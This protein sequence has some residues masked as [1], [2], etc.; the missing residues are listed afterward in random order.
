MPDNTSSRLFN[1]VKQVLNDHPD[2][3]HENEIRRLIQE[4]S[5]L[6]QRPTEI[7]QFLRSFPD[8]FVQLAGGIWRLKS[9]LQAE[10]ISLGLQEIPRSRGDVEIPY[11]INLPSLDS[12]IVFDL[13][14]SG[15]K[16]DRD[17]II[18][19]SAVRIV[20]GQPTTLTT[21]DH[22]QSPAIFNSYVNLQGR[23]L[24]FSLKVKLGFDKHSDWET[25]LQ[26]AP[27]VEEV[28]QNFR[29]WAGDLPLLA[30]NAR[31]DY[32]FLSK[33]ATQINWQITNPIIDTME[34]ACL[35]RP[36]LNTFTLSELSKSFGVCEGQSG[37]DQVEQWANQ[38]E[39][40][41]FSWQGFHNAIVDV[42]VLAAT[43][44]RLIAALQQRL[45]N[46]PDLAREFHRLMP[47]AA[48]ALSIPPIP[49]TPNLDAALKNLPKVVF[50]PDDKLPSLT[51]NFTP[52]NVETQFTQ[53]LDSKGY[54]RRLS[55]L[56]MIKAIGRGL[57]ENRFMAIEAPTGTGKTF[58]YLV[59]SVFWSRT[60]G[61]TVAI[62]T[63]TRLLQDQMANDLLKVHDQLGVDFR[64]TVLKGLSNYLCLDR[65][66]AVYAQ[67]E[68]TSLDQEQRFAWL[69]LLSW[70]TAT[71]TG[72]LDELSYW[73]ITTFPILAQLCDSLR[74]DR[75]ECSYDRCAA[76]SLCFH[77]RAYRQA[78]TSD[79]VVMNHALLLAKDWP[80]SNILFSQVMIDE[81][82]NLED[83][84]TAAATEEVSWDSL[85]YLV[86]RL[87]D[88]RTGQGLLVR[89]KDKNIA[90]D[91]QR[92]VAAAIQ[93]R[94]V[95]I[96]LIRDFGSQL[97][98]YIELNQTKVDPRYGAK[99][100]L[101][102]D[103]RKANPISWQPVQA[104]R[105]RLI[106]ELQELALILQR[107]Q[108]WLIPNRLSIFHQQTQNELTYLY[109]KLR[110]QAE[111]L[112]TL[113]KVGFDSLKVVHWLEVEQATPYE[114]SRITQEYTG[115]YKWAVKRAPVR[116]GPYL[117]ENL[118]KNKQALLLTSATLGTTQE[119]GLGFVLDRLGLLDRIQAPNA[120]KLAPELDYSRSLFAVA[121]YMR[122]DARP[123]E[124]K[125]F[126]DEV[127][128]E[129]GWFF[130]FTGGNGLTLF[131]ARERML[132]AF[133]EVEPTLGQYSISVG[134]QGETA[135]RKALLEEL[136]N[137]PGSV[138]LGLKSF[139]E[140][141]DVPGPN[142][143]YVVMEKL[144]FPMLGEPIIRA[145]A[146]ELRAKEISDFRHYLLPL[147]L[148]LFKQGFGRLIRDE[149]DMGAVLLLD[150]RV[151]SREYW[152]DI[153][154][155]LPG[156][157]DTGDNSK[158][159]QIL[160]FTLDNEQQLSRK[161]V[162]RS[163]A[164]FMSKAPPEWQIDPTWLQSI[165]DLI[166]D[167][168]L[169]G[170]ERLLAQLQ[171]PNI[172]PADQLAAVW[173]KVMLALKELFSFL[174]W[175]LPE[176]EDVVKSILTG[177]DTLVILPTGSGKS[178][179]FQLPALLRDGT[180]L[181]FSPLKSLM[182]DQVDKLIDRGLTVADR[183]DSTQTA[184]E[185][186]RVYQRMRDGTTRLVYIAPERVR[187]PKLIAALRA[188]KNIVQ[189]V[190]DEAHCVYMW[191]QSF[192]PDF[193]YINNLVDQ[194]TQTR[195]Q[196][197]P[198]AAL[199][200]T[201]TPHVRQAIKDQLHLINCQ[202]IATNPNR[203]ELRFVVYN[204]TSPGYRLVSRRDK[205][206][207]LLRILKTADRNDESAI[208]YVS[209]TREA[210]RLTARLEAAG[211]DARY[212]HGKMDDQARQD[213][214]DL[215]LEGQ[216]KIIVATKA[217][218]MGIDKSDVRYVIHFQIPGDLESYFQEAG[219]AGRDH[220]VSWCV[221]LF[222]PDDLYIHE[223]YFIPNSLPD[224]EQVENVL[225]WLRRRFSAANWSEIYLD[226]REMADALGFDEDRELGI[227]LHLLEAQKFLQRGLDVTL[228][229]SARL[230]APLPI[231]AA[232]AAQLAPGPVSA[233]LPA[234]L[235]S[236][237]VNE[238]A[239]TELRVIEAAQ[240]FGL[241]P[242][243]LDNLFYD[244]SLRGLLI[245]RS[246][247]RAITLIPSPS[248][249][250]SSKPTLDL[251]FVQAIQHEMTNNLRAMR[252][253]A[254][255]LNVG[256][257]CRISLL[258]YFGFEK[259]P[260]RK[261]HCCSYC[262]VNLAV[263][264]A[265]A[266]QYEDLSDPGRYHDAKYTLLKAIAW[267]ATLA[268]TKGRAPY[269]TRT[270]AYLLLGNDFMAT[271]YET[272]PERKK[273]RRDFIL[274]SEHFGALEGLSNGLDT[275]LDLSQ[276][277]IAEGYITPTLRQWE[278]GQYEYLAPTPTG[279]S[280]LDQGQLFET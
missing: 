10:E 14:T 260:T 267:N 163:I 139:W 1:A 70:L 126:V 177:Q 43:T 23:V 54:K 24:P 231:I 173:Q 165:L 193:L 189:V 53:M 148:I 146:A 224:A 130:R 270:L 184:E 159:P 90:P 216:V 74:S 25:E 78:E 215:F 237:G 61:Q 80:E 79:I 29:R 57:L 152:R 168:L 147:M 151:W 68:H 59:P 160:N 142:L 8:H 18:Q 62:S 114:P 194:I 199:T 2:G 209:T 33:A 35:A 97:K 118:Y 191:G 37:G 217:F 197:P 250:N 183:V 128:Q 150:K 125:N 6:R 85:H 246:F 240:T 131:T 218:G 175:R 102:A 103:P 46:H 263:P 101:E 7:Q 136:K 73:A 58:A 66:A 176:Q 87:I 187:D 36:E 50:P 188:A 17:Q 106:H 169:T 232:Q 134:C 204:S 11:L 89:I 83:A 249:Q 88:Q 174:S 122:S 153:V 135:G 278:T 198:V 221:L 245:Y 3:L 21:T 91:G 26:S 238:I 223:N 185:Q 239:R 257:C 107:L 228:K 166:P 247:A 27:P 259:P 233:A 200:A 207:L 82:H 266:P 5:G 158:A 243:A 201:A 241:N 275:L 222:H 145:R 254:E 121:R 171:V 225:Y 276:E 94:N 268:Q 105:E 167:E 214:Q 170:L 190:V 196:R 251:S 273:A 244:L 31:F 279:N 156:Y 99:L 235:A 109:D 252:R 277:L 119:A 93:R 129:L 108:E 248:L 272:D 96:T 192:R 32:G 261:D 63:Q 69:Y 186:E 230:L 133:T 264:W 265:N 211:L 75:G 269:G 123:S 132:Q 56:Q 213:V 104:A 52:E 154:L 64:Y 164:D 253:Y 141:V 28:L 262:D 206:R 205:M 38:L 226:P 149:N 42:L 179:T 13:E 45:T 116:V 111:L 210:E 60:N 39:I 16:S 4:T 181:V 71:Q 81:A 98:R 138:L 178:L 195:G 124:V 236:Q 117:E 110:E 34:I 212:Y 242:L 76:C 172:V 67:T 255:N 65:A 9:V 208:V 20:N 180:T 86:N 127:S 271:R 203:P 55:Q 161:A 40:S 22:L 137:R 274:A 49:E 120:I 44:P 84:A 219:R 220:Q 41:A 182:K 72:I 30:H 112:N 202:E 47:Q 115:P 19:I 256:D 144:P 95:L 258:Q 140:G 234:I 155:S 51:F 280:R 12:Y 162:Y 143:S 100:S 48:Q 77:R 229:A 157:T 113:L 227:Q 15:I 92:L